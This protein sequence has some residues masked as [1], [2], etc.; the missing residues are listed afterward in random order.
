MKQDRKS[1][2][3]NSKLYETLKSHCK[4]RGL[5]LKSLVEK[6]I[7]QK[8]QDGKISSIPNKDSE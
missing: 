4:E 2:P 7:I 8:L 1:I 3:I 5:I 6:L